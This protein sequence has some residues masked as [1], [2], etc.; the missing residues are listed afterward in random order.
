MSPQP[1]LLIQ[2]IVLYT[3]RSCWPVTK[4]TCH[5]QIC[6]DQIGL[7]TSLGR[8]MPV[9]QGCI[10]I[11]GYPSSSGRSSQRTGLQTDAGSRLSTVVFPTAVNSAASSGRRSSLAAGG[12]GASSRLGQLSDAATSDSEGARAGQSPSAREGT[13]AGRLQ[14]ALSTRNMAGQAPVGP[15]DLAG[16]S[17]ADGGNRGLLGVSGQKLLEPH[18]VNQEVT[19]CSNH[20]GAG[21]RQGFAELSQLQLP[22]AAYRT[23]A[24]ADIAATGASLHNQE[25]TRYGSELPHHQQTQFASAAMVQSPAIANAESGKSASGVILS[26]LSSAGPEG[27]SETVSTSESGAARASEKAVSAPGQSAAALGHQAQPEGSSLQ[28]PLATEQT[29]L[30]GAKSAETQ[31]QPQAAPEPALA[32]SQAEQ[33]N[34]EEQ[35]VLYNMTGQTGSLM[36]MAPEVSP[37]FECNKQGTHGHAVPG[38]TANPK[39]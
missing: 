10:F 20:H 6:L 7:F 2:C 3:L 4:R 22:D 32:M 8:N 37:E 23:H 17:D 11:A 27:H 39:L 1:E 5:H 16:V 33:R 9:V 29:A 13:G 14:N 31:G 28:L 12:S 25:G 24:A 21:S 18:A 36:Y 34:V 30:S 35:E 26:P 19:A 38:Q 15:D